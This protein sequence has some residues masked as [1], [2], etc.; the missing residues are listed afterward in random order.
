MMVTPPPRGMA[1]P[2]KN[3]PSAEPAGKKKKELRWK[4]CSFSYWKNPN[5]AKHTEE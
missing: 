5:I 3:P 2:V 1:Q 4:M